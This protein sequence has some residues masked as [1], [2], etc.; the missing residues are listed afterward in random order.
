M[1]IRYHFCIHSLSAD[2][3]HL[4]MAAVLRLTEVLKQRGNNFFT[5]FLLKWDRELYME[6]VSFTY[7]RKEQGPANCLKSDK[8]S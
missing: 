1:I 2:G 7:D 3:S 5:V 4:R 6:L 8:M